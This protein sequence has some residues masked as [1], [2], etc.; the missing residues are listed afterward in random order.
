[1]LERLLTVLQKRRT[2]YHHFTKKEVR[3]FGLQGLRV[4]CT[5]KEI[6]NK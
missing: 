3:Y 1:M 4:Y 2:I 6:R 5:V